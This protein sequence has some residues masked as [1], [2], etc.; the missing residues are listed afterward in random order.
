MRVLEY[1]VQEKDRGRRLGSVLERDMRISRTLISRLKFRHA[2]LLDGQSARTD[3]RLQPG[4]TVYAVLED[5]KN[6]WEGLVPSDVLPDVRYEDED[7]LI[8]CKPAPLPSIASARQQGDTL[9]GRMYAYFGCGEHFVYR[10]VNRLDK[11]TSGLMLVAKNSF[12]QEKLQKDLHT[13]HFVREYLAVCE[14]VLPGREGVIDLPIARE[15]AD[16]VRRVIR[17]DGRRAVTHYRVLRE[18]NGRSLVRLQLETGRTHQIRVHLSA[19]GCPIVGDYLY[20]AEH[21]AL[22]GRFA[23]HACSVRFRHPVTGKIIEMEEKLPR[24]LEKLL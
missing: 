17:E 18:Q 2:I 13:E 14:G 5:E 1:T 10:P 3:T 11:G 21:T 23:L 20:G 8:V 15:K 24:E 22:P 4:Q 9:E 6:A 16:S 12:A 7:V 19:M